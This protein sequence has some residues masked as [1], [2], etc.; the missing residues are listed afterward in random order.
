[1]DIGAKAVKVSDE[2]LFRLSLGGATGHQAFARDLGV[3]VP[4]AELN[5]VIVAL[6]RVFIANGNRTDRKRARLK[7]LLETWTLERYLSETEKLLG[8]ELRKAPLTPDT[9][10][11]PGQ[12]LPHSH[13]GVYP[14]KQ[15]GLSYVGVALPVGQITPKQ[16]LRIAELADLYGSGEI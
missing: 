7:H 10:C 8:R 9:L 5:Q 12:Q 14:Q 16:L 2:V 3:L 1:N 13:L 6:V 15:A 4:S 11:Y